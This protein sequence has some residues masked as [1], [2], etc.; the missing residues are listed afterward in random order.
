MSHPHS[1]CL[2]QNHPKAE[3]LPI[4]TEYLLSEMSFESLYVAFTS[5]FEQLYNSLLLE[6]EPWT[7]PLCRLWCEDDIKLMQSCIL[8]NAVNYSL[9]FRET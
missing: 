4:A 9:T 7:R 1:C 8:I 6:I 3:N 2:H 5:V